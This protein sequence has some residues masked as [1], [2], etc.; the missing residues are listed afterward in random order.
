[1]ENTNKTLKALVKEANSIENINYNDVAIPQEVIKQLETE[2]KEIFLNACKTL[3]NKSKKAFFKSFFAVEVKKELTEKETE[4]AI[5]EAVSCKQSKLKVN[6]NGLIDIET[7]KKVINFAD[8]LN[9]KIELI[10][11][12]N[13]DKKPTKADITNANRFYYGSYGKGYI[14]I[15]T[16]NARQFMSIGNADDSKEEYTL[17][18]NYEKSLDMLNTKYATLNKEN[19]FLLTSNNAYTLQI[20]DIIEYF[21]ENTDVKL[22]NYHCKAVFQ[23]I[24]N[25]NKFGKMSIVSQNDVLNILAIVYRYAFNGY[26]LPTNDKSNIYK[27]IK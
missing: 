24:C 23:M 5:K 27:T 17:N 22:F 8:V 25:R 6:D 10:A 3:A 11:F 12:K 18:A 16:H 13:A 4:K 21:T 15:I 14:D 19:P 26:K 2:N 20:M 1:M 9:A 7:T